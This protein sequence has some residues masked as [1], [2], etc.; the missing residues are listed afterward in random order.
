MSEEKST[1]NNNEEMIKKI[2]SLGHYYVRII[3]VDK[4]DLRM[5]PL[6]AL[7]DKS[8][9]NKNGVPF[10]ND[11]KYTSQGTG[12]ICNNHF[13]SQL[14]SNYSLETFSIN[15]D[16]SFELW[17]AYLEDIDNTNKIKNAFDIDHF[18]QIIS[19]I[20]FYATRYSK[21]FKSDL[22]IQI[23]LINNQ[24]RQ[25]TNEYNPSRDLSGEFICRSK[26]TTISLKIFQKDTM[27]FILPNIL[28]C[29]VEVLSQYQLLE[30][31]EN[32]FKEIIQ[33]YLNKNFS[34]FLEVY[35]DKE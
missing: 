2:E 1:L 21:T 24:K 13:I 35:K 12:Y 27:K 31:K 29:M 5:E 34:N 9:I 32:H 28:K 30:S 26:M 19:S 33:E 18:L 15:R 23:G 20:I 6:M 16:G 17:K 11:G 4:F 22:N 25:L 7:L 3:P 10:P 8:R 14:E